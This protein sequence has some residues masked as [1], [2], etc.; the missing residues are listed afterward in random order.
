MLS[1]D[2]TGVETSRAPA[3]AGERKT[4]IIRSRANGLK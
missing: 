1:I 4:T 3:F 2:L